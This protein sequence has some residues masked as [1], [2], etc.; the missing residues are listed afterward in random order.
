M[1]TLSIICVAVTLLQVLDVSITGISAAPTSGI[2]ASPRVV[3]PSNNAAPNSTRKLRT[4]PRGLKSGNKTTS[5]NNV[6]S[7]DPN[8]QPGMDPNDQDSSE[9][10]PPKTIKASGKR[11]LKTAVSIG[12]Q[13]GAGLLN[14]ITGIMKGTDSAFDFFGKFLLGQSKNAKDLAK[15]SFN[16]ASSFGNTATNGAKNVMNSAKTIGDQGSKTLYN[17]LQK[18]TSF[19]KK[20]TKLGGTVIDTPISIGEDLVTTANGI[21]KI[22]SKLSRMGSER[23]VKPALSVLGPISD[24]DESEEENG[25][26]AL[27]AEPPIAPQTPPSSPKKLVKKKTSTA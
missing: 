6:A 3:A 10:E 17:T 27:D 16:M 23:L 2:P 15:Q 8:S 1:R 19:G 11:V 7:L 18:T 13:R 21:A 4:A 22:P 20:L 25:E 9:A 12:S 14:G 5:P 26:N 24:E